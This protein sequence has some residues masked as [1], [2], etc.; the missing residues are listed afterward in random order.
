M[1]NQLFLATTNTGK[2]QEFKLLLKESKYSLVTPKETGVNLAV[3]ENGNSFKENA[4]IKAKAYSIA[5]N[6]LCLAD[7]SGIEIDALNGMPGVYS[8]RYGGADLTDKDRVNLVLSK[9]RDVPWSLR[10]ARFRTSLALAW[11][12][13]ENAVYEGVLEGVIEFESRGAN[14]FGYDPIFFL[15]SL[16]ST[17]GELTNIPKAQISH[18]SIAVSKLLKFLLA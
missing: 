17:V 1:P 18:R 7:D 8:A 16:Q 2:I 12:E 9:M 3:E 10:T 14:G 13:G 11:P 5:T 6:F 4:L 15:P